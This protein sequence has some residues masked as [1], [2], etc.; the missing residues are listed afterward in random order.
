MNNAA[1][2]IHPFELAGL[3][4]APFRVIGAAERVFQACPGEPVK[5]GGCCAYCATG[6]RYA[7]IVRSSDGKVFDVGLDCVRKVDFGAYLEA[8]EAFRRERA[9]ARDAA[10]A[11]TRAQRIADAER[12]RAENEARARNEM[13]A[14]AAQIDAL[15]GGEGF[16]SDF[17]AR[18]LE[19]ARFSGTFAR[20]DHDRHAYSRGDSGL[21]RIASLYA[22][23]VAVGHVGVA[24]K[25]QSL[26]ARFIGVIA[27][28]TQFGVKRIYKFAH[29]REDGSV[30]IIVWP[31][32]SYITG[33]NDQ[34]V[35]LGDEVS[36]TATVE[37][38]AYQGKAQTTVKRPKFSV[39]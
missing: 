38:G 30:G 28:E 13:P 11:V 20:R 27:F 37:H 24:G 25:R 35:H 34:A 19:R 8:R 3:G 31:T 14:V 39:G 32:T 9:Q 4:L 16:A 7:A 15:M 26:R 23:H 5:A 17:A 10:A 36:I 1:T 6:I 12:E 21:E 2:T 18:I 22:E 29:T 33:V